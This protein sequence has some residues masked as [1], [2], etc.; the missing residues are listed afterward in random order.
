MQRRPPRCAHG[1]ANRRGNHQRRNDVIAAGI[2]ERGIFTAA[3][4]LARRE[5]AHRHAS[6]RGGRKTHGAIR[7]TQTTSSSGLIAHRA[8]AAGIAAWHGVTSIRKIAASLLAAWRGAR[9]SLKRVAY[10]A[11]RHKQR[12]RHLYALSSSS[13]SISAACGAPARCTRIKTSRWRNTLASSRSS[14][15][16]SVAA[17]PSYGA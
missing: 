10:A 7:K 17:H 4:T 16:K 2:L 3:I 5:G 8:L 12:W 6:K 9:L 15:V 13:A 11:A 14:G 1:W